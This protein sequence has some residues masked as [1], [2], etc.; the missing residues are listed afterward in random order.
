M[1]RKCFMTME[2]ALKLHEEWHVPA[3]A[4]LRPLLK[5]KA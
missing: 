5:D 4:L 1:R 3:E 2:Q